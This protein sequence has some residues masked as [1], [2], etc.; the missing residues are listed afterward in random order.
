[1]A[2]HGIIISRAYEEVLELAEKAQ[3]PVITTLLGISSFPT[4]H[5]LNV[6]MPG[7]HGMS[8]ASMAIDEADLLISLG[9]RFDDRVTGKVSAFAPRAKVIHVDV[10]PS[11][12]KQER[13][14]NGANCG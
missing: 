11:R 5:F 7:M 13:Q 9:M 3:I 10:D 12:D 1:M 2:G 8:Y 6:G 4:E 14:G